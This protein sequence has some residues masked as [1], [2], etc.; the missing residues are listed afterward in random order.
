MLLRAVQHRPLLRGSAETDYK[1]KIIM[2]G[3]KYLG[4]SRMQSSGTLCHVA[5]VRTDVS[6]G[7]SASIIKVTRSAN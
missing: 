2:Y 5:L 1:D 3:L 7:R 4:F 6:E